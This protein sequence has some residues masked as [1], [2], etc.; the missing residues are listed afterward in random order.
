MCIIKHESDFVEIL[1]E[2]PVVLICHFD[3]DSVV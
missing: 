1:L 2:R 3:L